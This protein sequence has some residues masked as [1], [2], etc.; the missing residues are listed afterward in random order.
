MINTDFLVDVGRVSKEC[1]EVG[2]FIMIKT[3]AVENLLITGKFILNLT[4]EQFWKVRCRLEVPEL[5]IWYVQG[6]K[7]LIKSE[8]QA[9]PQNMINM[10]YQVLE[11]EGRE[12]HYTGI[13]INGALCLYTDNIMYT[14]LMAERVDMLCAPTEFRRC[15]EAVVIDN[16]HI[17]TV[18][19]DKYLKN[20]Y[21][22]VL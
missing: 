6:K 15:G 21:V 5:G 19:S 13:N 9:D 14:G 2:E 1:K 10:Y 8:Q 20:E 12:I 18:Q 17:M 3:P 16:Q 11:A 4:S 22:K 7:S